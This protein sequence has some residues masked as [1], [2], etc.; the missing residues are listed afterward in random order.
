MQHVG[1]FPDKF[2]I[3]FFYWYDLKSKW[4]DVT[5]NC[6]AFRKHTDSQEEKSAT[7]DVYFSISAQGGENEKQSPLPK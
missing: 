1:A 5:S 4:K 7:E 2:D 3:N 6:W